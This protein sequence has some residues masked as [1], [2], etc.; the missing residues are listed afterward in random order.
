[1][2]LWAAS[3]IPAIWQ[4]ISQFGHYLFLGITGA[5]FANATGAGG[6][7]IFIP[8]FTHLGFND[9]QSLSTSFAIQCFGMTAGAISWSWYYLRHQKTQGQWHYFLPFVSII[10]LFSIAGIWTSYGANLPS[11]A[12]LHFGFSLFSILLGITL[13]YSSQQNKKTHNFNIIH[14]DY[15]ML[16]SIGFFGGIITTWLSV[17]VG[18][19]VVIYLMLRGVCAKMA[20]ATGVVVSAIS[21]WSASPVHLGPNSAAD[22]Y[23]VLFAGPGAVIG[24]LLARKLALYLPVLKLKLFF[25]SWII[26]TGAAMLAE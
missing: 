1:M 8:V 16:A 26:L 11:P 23:L 18:E 17:G 24:G 2:S 4:L 22:F 7:V 19:L 25:S 9:A 3:Q 13:I 14:I 20:I 6:G 15:L 12:S 21:V 5:I 10:S